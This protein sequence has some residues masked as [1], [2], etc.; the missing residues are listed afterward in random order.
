MVVRLPTADEYTRPN[1]LER[2][3]PRFPLFSA[4][5]FLFPRTTFHITIYRSLHF[6][7]V[8][9]LRIT[10]SQ[11]EF[12]L[13]LSS[14][15]NTSHKL[16]LLLRRFAIFYVS[17]FS[18]LP[19]CSYSSTVLK[20]FSDSKKT[21]ASNVSND[22]FN[23]SMTISFFNQI[24]SLK[25]CSKFEKHREELCALTHVTFPSN[26]TLIMSFKSS[27]LLPFVRIKYSLRYKNWKYTLAAFPRVYFNLTFSNNSR[28]TGPSYAKGLYSLA[29]KASYS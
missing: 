17:F 9:F 29:T 4:S 15:A 1:L 7:Y 8:N 3:R 26:L 20:S 22:V 24:L 13:F 28:E 19:R 11:R 2:I 5:L 27:T 16:I 18:S 10:R 23:I 25:N 14:L 12:V 6:F 21:F